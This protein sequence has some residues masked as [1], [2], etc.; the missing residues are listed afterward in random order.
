MKSATFDLKEAKSA[1]DSLDNR[2]DAEAERLKRFLA[3]PDLSRTPGSP[4]EDLAQRVV[5]LSRFT[6]FYVL[7]VPEIVRYDLS[8]DMFNFP[9]DH[10]ARNPSDT[11]F[12][13]KEYILRPHTTVMWS[14]QLGLEDV[15]EKIAN[16]E[17]VGA[18][19]YGKVYRKDEIDRN[20][21]N[22]FHQIDGWYL[23]NKNEHIITIQDLQDILS[24]IAKT[25]FGADI[26][27]RF[28]KDQFP[29]T[30]PSIEMEVQINY[31][32]IEVL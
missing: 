9:A 2:H 19:S 16:G 23:C 12:L 13:N 18:L 29:Y 15:K 4:L 3:M 17:S 1:K 31:K 27:Y 14:Y 5:N 28:N 26:K 20:H 11:Y 25:I 24:E 7:N 6:D 21:M 22:V 32:W 8:F 30:D 10:P